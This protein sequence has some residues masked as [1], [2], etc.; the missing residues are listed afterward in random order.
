[1]SRKGASSGVRYRDERGRFVRPETPGARPVPVRESGAG[2]YRDPRTGRFAPRPDDR[3]LIPPS[4]V[5]LPASGRIP[6]QREREL[7]QIAAE[8]ESDDGVEYEDFD[9]GDG[10]Y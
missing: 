9:L 7:A 2:R 10:D 5:S 3:P 4:L 6:S 1:M 8:Y